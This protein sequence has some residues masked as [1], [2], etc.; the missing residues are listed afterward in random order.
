[1]TSHP[2]AAPETGPASPETAP[3]GDGHGRNDVSAARLALGN[4]AR[5]GT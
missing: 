3:S 2:F 1:M 5:V 4:P